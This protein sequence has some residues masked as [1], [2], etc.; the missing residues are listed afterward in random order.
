MSVYVDELF[1]AVAKESEARRVGA[2]SGHQWCHLWTDG[3]LE[4]L[5]AFAAR[6][7]MR[8]AWFQNHALLPHY[9]LVPSRRTKAI[10]LGAI[11]A[12]VGP[13]LMKRRSAQA[14]A[15]AA[16]KRRV[17]EKANARERRKFEP[18]RR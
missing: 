3:D 10:A 7:G 12:P 14:E 11:V 17:E 6:I 16:A 4:E 2:R 18:W 15:V 5:H 9:D 1:V 13:E 8:R